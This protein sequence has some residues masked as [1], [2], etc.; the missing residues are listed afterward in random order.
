M[1]PIFSSMGFTIC[2]FIFLL[3]IMIMYIIK[4]KFKSLENNIFGF[5]IIFTMFLLVLEMLCVITMSMRSKIPVLNEV[6]CR[7]Y[8]LGSIIWTTCLIAYFWSLGTKKIKKNKITLFIVSFIV[9]VLLFTIS[10]LLPI[11][12][13]GGNGDLYVI[14]GPAVYILYVI[15]FVLIIV[16]L[17]TLLKNPLNISS[18]SRIPIYLS[19]IFFI[20]VTCLQVV[21]NYDFN[22]LTYIFAFAVI[23]MYLTVESQD[24]KLLNEL[25]EKKHQA[26][27]SDRAKTEFLTNMSHEIRTPMN[28]IMGFSES[29]LSEEKLTFEMVKK[30]VENINIASKNLLDLINN[31]LDISRIE[32][33]KEKVE[34][35]EYDLDA[36]VFE[37]NSTISSKINQDV[38]DFKINVNEDI[39]SKYY[40][41][42]FKLYKIII[43]ILQNAMKYTSYGKIELSITGQEQDDAFLFDI[44]VS[45]TGH[46]MKYEDFEKDFNDFVTLG[47]STQ[48]KIDSVTLGLI[49]VKRLLQMLDGNITFLNEKGQ[50]TKYSVS[51]KQKVIDKTPVGNVFLT[52]KSNGI[53]TKF[54]DLSGKRVLVVD[55]NEINIKLAS[56]LLNQYKLEIDSALS[57]RQ[58]LDMVKQKKYDL[59]FLDHMMPDLDGIQTLK[60]LKQSG[61]FVPPVV[62]LTANSYSGIKEKYTEEGFSDYLSKP[63]NVK[64][65]NKIINKYFNVEQKR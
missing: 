45:N 43:L 10:C 47:N 63:I 51:L 46:A 7:C 53:N 41:D 62:A 6:L 15:S 21:L 32:S 25:E 29:L 49:I 42:Y 56:R 20:S 18:K 34:E 64:D 60:L 30:D 59:I 58:C 37:V 57:G 9:V 36:L 38:L 8:I 11:T 4:K 3:L 50:G 31:I 13:T 61:Y 28:T 24:K 33:G 52:K 5:M 27:L 54:L 44:T 1:F 26:E 17:F 39:P 65:L 2:A 19:L 35:K 14:G 12:Y 22:D 23:T 55:D 16:M 40:G 48:N